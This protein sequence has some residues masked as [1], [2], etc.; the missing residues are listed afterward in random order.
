M[1]VCLE[2]CQELCR[3]YIYTATHKHTSYAQTHKH[4]QRTHT[5]SGDN[6]YGSGIQGDENAQRFKDT[7]E[8]VFDAK[9]DELNVPFYPI[10]G[11]HDH[12]SWH[13]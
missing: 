13:L 8:N 6:F 1:C 7:F 4:T 5:L 9:Y 2:L 10:A 12:R 11:N 3:L